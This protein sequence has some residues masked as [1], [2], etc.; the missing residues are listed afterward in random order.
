ML[1]G[2][3]VAMNKV[4]SDLHKDTLSKSFGVIIAMY[5]PKTDINH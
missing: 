5:E 2:E 3:A 1:L 4:A